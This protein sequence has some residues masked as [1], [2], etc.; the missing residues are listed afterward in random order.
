MSPAQGELGTASSGGTS[1]SSTSLGVGRAPWLSAD[2]TGIATGSLNGASPSTAVADGV[3]RAPGLS[4]DRTGIATGSLGGTGLPAAAAGGVGQA[5]RSGADQTGSAVGSMD[6]TGPGSAAAGGG[7][8]QGPSL[9]ETGTDSRALNGG[10]TSAVGTGAGNQYRTSG[11]TQNGVIVPSTAGAGSIAGNDSA[12]G[13]MPDVLPQSDGAATSS[14][15]QGPTSAS[16]G[17]EP[18]TQPAGEQLAPY[19]SDLRPNRGF[20]GEDVQISSPGGADQPLGSTLGGEFSP[21]SSAANS[22]F[23][24]PWSS[25]TTASDANNTS[26][27]AA[28]A[29]TSSTS[30]SAAQGS[31]FALGQDVGPKPDSSNDMFMPPRPRDTPPM[32]SID[33]PF[34][35]VVVCRRFDVLL[36]PGGYRLTARAIKEQ[37]VKSDGLL[38]REIR[39]IVHRRAVVDPMIRPRP[40]IKFRVEAGGADTFWMAR[41]QL[42]FS[43][44]EW[45][46]SLQVSGSQEPHV[47]SKETW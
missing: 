9:G 16:D 15:N 14:R 44:P 36:Q 32:G 19:P 3:G 34:E 29:S 18:S 26:G 27:G 25:S 6:G 41:R 45:P 33:V 2:R 5:Q 35:I 1:S 43:L 23:G 20:N 8:T 31:G 10:A 17:S 7:P 21:A 11:G 40:A 47:F 39:A 42:L 30:S 22:G 28:P 38:A 37:G 12:G 46:M 4:A 24:M 13:Q